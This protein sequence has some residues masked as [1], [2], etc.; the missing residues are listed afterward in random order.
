MYLIKEYMFYVTFFPWLDGIALLDIT[1]FDASFK[2]NNHCV[3]QIAQ[4]ERTPVVK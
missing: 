4:K 2:A 3:S 1:T